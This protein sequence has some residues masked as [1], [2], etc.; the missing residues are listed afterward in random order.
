MLIISSLFQSN[1]FCSV[2][3]QCARK[4][5][6]TSKKGCT[7]R[8]LLLDKSLFQ[9]NC[10]VHVK[11][12]MGV[13]LQEG[14]HSENRRVS[15]TGDGQAEPLAILIQEHHI[16][17]E[18]GG[19]VAREGDCD[20][21]LL[22]GNAYQVALWEVESE[23]Q[24][25]L[26]GGRPYLCIHQHSVHHACT[27]VAEQARHATEDVA[28]NLQHRSGSKIQKGCTFIV[29]YDDTNHKMCN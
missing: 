26:I 11:Q 18:A 14:L 29:I 27:L 23:G 22:L 4:W 9:S 15:G 12:E 25:L 20:W 28:Q 2:S 13:Y 16:G 5:V 21:Q 24:M 7:V 1:L 19:A 6:C 3:R 10:F 17:R 8:T